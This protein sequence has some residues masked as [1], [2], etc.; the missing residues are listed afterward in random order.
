MIVETLG[1]VQLSIYLIKIDADTGK[2]AALANMFSLTLEDKQKMYDY[3]Y[4]RVER[5]TNILGSG[6]DARLSAFC[7]FYKLIYS[8]NITD[9]V[10]CVS[11]A[12]FDN[13]SP[14]PFILNEGIY[15]YFGNCLFTNSL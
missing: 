14:C 7:Q 4:Q 9:G 10:E 6:S 13:F 15:F 3:G 12:L 2:K 11:R 1:G 8:H 5:M